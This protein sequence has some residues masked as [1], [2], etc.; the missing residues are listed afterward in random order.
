[1][2]NESLI[3]KGFANRCI[4][5]VASFDLKSANYSSVPKTKSNVKQ[6]NYACCTMTAYSRIIFRLCNVCNVNI[7]C[8]L[9]KDYLYRKSNELTIYL[10]KYAE[11]VNKDIYQT[12]AL[13]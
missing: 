7:P 10:L 1:M 12:V 2:L 9:S 3:I 13:K 8:I 4:Q 5:Q 11:S 6:I